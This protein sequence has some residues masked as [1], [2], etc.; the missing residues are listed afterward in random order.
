MNNEFEKFDAPPSEEKEERIPAPEPAGKKETGAEHMLELSRKIVEEASMMEVGEE[1]RDKEGNL[2][3]YPEGPISNL[4]RESELYW[5]IARTKTFKDFFGDWQKSP[6]SS[7]TSKI[8]DK[9]GEPLVVFRGLSEAISPEDFY[10]K[11][12]YQNRVTGSDKGVHVSPSHEVVSEEYAR[13]GGMYKLFVNA[14]TPAA[15]ESVRRGLEEMMDEILHIPRKYFK[16]PKL[17]IR[18]YDC[19]LGLNRNVMVGDKSVSSSSKE[20]EDLYELVVRD[21]DQIFILPDNPREQVD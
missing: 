11:D 8:V 10:N 4:G 19:V 1:D 6:S 13:G 12:F 2:L 21:P 9:N 20:L 16:I 3:V 5:K 17:S 15:K 14:R 18:F 7:G